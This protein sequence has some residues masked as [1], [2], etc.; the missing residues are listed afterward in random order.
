MSKETC[1][2][3]RTQQQQKPKLSSLKKKK[4]SKGL[5]QL[6][7]QR[8]YKWPMSTS[9]EIRE[10]QHKTTVRYNFIPIRKTIIF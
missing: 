5:E 8:K 7:L 9:L 10:M 3:K 1:F 4:M 6:F 2:K